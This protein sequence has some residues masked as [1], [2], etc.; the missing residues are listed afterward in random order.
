MGE[1][2]EG[3]L[4]F[5]SIYAANATFVWRVLRGMGV[6]DAAVEDAVQDVF[7]VVH[8][9]LGEFEG[10]SLVKTWLF[11]IAYRVA[12]DHRKRG[13][14]AGSLDPIDDELRDKRPGPAEMAEQNQQLALLARLFDRLDDDKRAVLVLADIEGM[15]APEIAE[16]VSAPLNT[17]YTRLRRA[18]AEIEAAIAGLRSKTP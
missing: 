2:S 3:A 14:R 9:R 8:R 13:R 15:T 10:R 16:I 1:R 7:I 12:C 18:R 4:T 5:E 17:V 6:P 11:E